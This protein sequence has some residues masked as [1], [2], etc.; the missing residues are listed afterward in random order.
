MKRLYSIILTLG[1]AMAATSIS[2]QNANPYDSYPVYSGNDLGVFYS[3]R[4]TCF[5]IWAGKATEA[6]VRLYDDGYSGK[7][8]NQVNMFPAGDGV[9]R[10]CITGDH[11][12]K[13]YTFQ[14]KVDGK[15]LRE[16]PDIYARAV[17]INGAR[18][19]IVDL[20]STNPEGW[21]KDK[22]PA[23]KNFNDIVLYETHVRD[24]SI[25]PNSGIQHKG[26]FLGLAEL[27]TKNPDGQLTGL[28]H[29]KELGVTHVHLLPSFDFNSIDEREP[30]AKYNWGYDPLNYNVPEGSYAT[31][32]KDGNVRIKEFKTMV[33]AMH[34]A[35]LRVILDVVY[36]HTSDIKNSNFSQFAPGYFYRQNPDGS[37]SNA[38]ACGNEVAS[39]RPMVRKFM[40]ESVVYWAKEYHLDG[41]RFD[42]MG[43]HDI[44]TMNQISAALHKID[45]TI[46]IYG[47]GWTAGNS[48]LP[49]EQRAV[50]KNTAKLDQIAVFSDDIRDGIHGGWSD[51]KEK[52][53]V[54]G[55][56]DKAESVKFG[57]VA[58]TQHPQIDYSKVNYSKTPWAAEPFQTIT[59]ASCHDDNTLFDRLKI[60]NPNT[61]EE[62]L[63]KMD[64]LANAIVLTSQGVP[65]LHSGAE[66]L[67]TKKGVA[68]SYNSPDSIN[69][70]DWSR[71]TKYKA[72]F[73]YYK[74]LVALRKNHPAFR[75]PSTQMIQ[76]NLKFI[77]SGDA[78][79]IA[80]QI[81]NNANGDKWRNI[82]VILNGSVSDETVK[83]PAG[84]WTLVANENGVNE[85]G[86]SAVSGE[87]KLPGTVAYVLYGE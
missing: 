43:V 5:K 80:Y 45:P 35:G 19:M 36:N 53:F 86:I 65:F 7:L 11:K 83:L 37:Y 73:D 13:Y 29:I 23:L 3:P 17:G 54:S 52:G 63:I 61:S 20:P 67:R 71:K 77:D 64:K 18:G 39:E 6:I 76:A 75:M 57:I 44:E 22:R 34:K 87:V 4:E 74:G 30:D 72:V 78:G 10:L 59:Y 14:V 84:K 69:Q 33:Q 50:K 16:S 51:V 49:E 68:N 42:L 21:N 15:W 26:K 31:D 55:A 60:S 27:N 56:A 32:A 46:F 58:S 24:I 47:E 62:D 12:N 41:F 66:M 48:P 82:L 28:S 9:W 70:I 8:M 79:V 1:F 81:G 25:G 38:T 85:K 40:I 2:A